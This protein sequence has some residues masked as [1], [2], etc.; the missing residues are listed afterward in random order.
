MSADMLPGHDL[1]FRGILAAQLLAMA[2]VRAFFGAPGARESLR[3]SPAPRAESTWLTTL[4]GLIA[5]LHFGG[6]VAYLADPAL[7][8]SSAFEAGAAI[9][10]LGIALS[11]L[12]VAGEIWAAVA[13]GSSYSPTLR[14][15]SERALV[16]SGPYRWIRHPLYAFWMPV[17]VGWGLAAGSWFVLASGT[18]LILVL[19]IVRVP[20]EEAMMVVGFGE[21]YRRYAARTG[22]FLP[23]F[24]ALGPNRD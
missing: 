22:R 6:I 8:R 11:C 5:L 16:T 2:G 4:L 19:R 24:R 17:M 15:S 20:R 3:T 14:V 21:S 18:V 23:R 13:L 1:W 7:L 9:R 12:G 10:W